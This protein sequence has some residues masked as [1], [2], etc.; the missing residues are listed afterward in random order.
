[1]LMIKTVELSIQ[2]L[3]VLFPALAKAGRPRHQANVAKHPR[4]SGRGGSLPHP[5]NGPFD[6]TPRPRPPPRPSPL[7]FPRRPPPLGQGGELST[8]QRR[9]LSQKS[10]S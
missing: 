3:S 7:F 6:R 1:K 9:R 2:T 5:L 4:R 8:W 10:Y